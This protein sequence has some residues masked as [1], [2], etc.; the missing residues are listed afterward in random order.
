MGG[1]I[2]MAAEAAYRV[3]SGKVSVLSKTE[4]YSPLLARLPN[5]M[6][7]TGKDFFKNKSV[8]AIGMG[9]GKSSWSKDLLKIALTS[10]L[11]KIID[12]DA[13][14]LIAASK[15]IP[16]LE[17][18][19]ITP[20]IGEATHLLGLSPSEI[21]KDRESSAKKL[22]KKFNC[23]VVLKGK[24]SLICGKDFLHECK[25]GNPGMA[26]AGMGD[27]LSGVIAGLVAQG[28][29]LKDATV[30]GVE[31]HAHAGD[32]VAKKQGKIGMMPQ[33]LLREIPTLLQ[34]H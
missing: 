22:Q 12:A 26:T 29:N 25:F 9:L 28:L 6:T 21:Q 32:A 1:A 17:N 20:H 14:N 4:N 31:L 7:A 5:V 30:F 24:N 3:G 27:V 23:I 34:R 10:D 33:D 18:S 19:V 11:P 8:I 15:K 13:L 16:D 2:I